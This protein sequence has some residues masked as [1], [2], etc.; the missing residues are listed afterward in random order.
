MPLVILTSCTH[1]EAEEPI[2][3]E[4][5]LDILLANLQNNVQQIN[6]SMHYN[7][8]KQ[9]SY[10]A[11]ISK[12]ALKMSA[13]INTTDYYYSSKVLLKTVNDRFTVENPNTTLAEQKDLM[14]FNLMYFTYS[15]GNSDSIYMTDS[16]INISFINKGA[17][18]S[19]ECGRAVVN[20]VLSIYF[21]NEKIVS[22]V[23][24]ALQGSKKI[25]TYYKYNEI[26]YT[27]AEAPEVAPTDTLNYAIYAI[28]QFS[29][30]YAD[31][32]LHTKDN[33]NTEAKISSI[34]LDQSKVKSV[35]SVDITDQNK[36]YTLTIN[37][38][39]KEMIVGVGSAITTLTIAYNSDYKI[40]NVKIN[41]TDYVLK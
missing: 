17:M 24:T 15:D 3:A 14:P 12:S 26:A 27:F 35:T 4:E 34:I 37:Y 8:T 20:G 11:I 23:F 38:N 39:S 19:F 5:K 1:I 7:D 29:K 2:T 32:T 25:T 13:K 33:H 31:M 28:S 6:G 40:N 22:S 10:D 41:T 21:E 18:F 30:K 16:T 36:Y 9:E